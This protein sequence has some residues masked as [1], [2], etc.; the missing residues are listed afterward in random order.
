[1]I[2]AAQ[3][4]IEVHTVETS[5]GY[6]LSMHRIPY[7]KTNNTMENRPIVFGMHG[8]LCSSADFVVTG[9][10]HA[11]SYVFADAGYDVW[12]G[13][14][15]GNTFSKNH[16][17]M[18]TKIPTFWNFTWH[19][20]GE[21]DVPAM[22]DYILER[23]NQTSLHYVGHSQG[24]TTILVTLSLLP[25]YNKKLITMHGMA[26]VAFMRHIPNPALRMLSKFTDQLEQVLINN[27]MYEFLPS[28]NISRLVGSIMCNDEA[29]TQEICSNALFLVCG[30]D[31][32]QLNR[33]RRIYFLERSFL[34]V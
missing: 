4:P 28:S 5:D 31:S 3:Y 8:M 29:V 27:Q 20:I 33:V 23:T 11:M 32:E 1:M 17:Y 7:G 34:S 24:V 2:E 18:S 21:Y 26:P 10:G 6:L 13:N 22:I 30:F 15:R 14:A 12:L 19:E 9:P 25:Q 16:M